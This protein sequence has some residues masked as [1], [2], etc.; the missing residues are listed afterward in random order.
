MSKHHLR[1]RSSPPGVDVTGP[2]PAS[3]EQVEDE[4]DARSLDLVQRVVISALAMVVGGSIS[5]VLAFYTAF[6]R[7]G[8][9][10]A[11]AIGLW[12]MAGV[13]GLLT[14]AVVLVINRR[15]TYSPLLVLGLLPMAVSAYWVFR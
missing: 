14:A 15:H 9:D 8:L 12:V 13:T 7:A 4:E 11:S 3:P 10:A 6:G 2:G 5:C 1:E